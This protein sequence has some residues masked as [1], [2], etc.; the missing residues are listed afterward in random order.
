[1]ALCLGPSFLFDHCPPGCTQVVPAEGKGGLGEETAPIASAKG[2]L[3]SEGEFASSISKMTSASFPQKTYLPSCFLL[4]P[5]LD[6]PGAAAHPGDKLESSL[7]SKRRLG[8]ARTMCPP[9]ATHQPRPP[10]VPLL[11]QC[12]VCAG[13]FIVVILPKCAW[14]V[15][16]RSRL[17]WSCSW[18]QV[19]CSG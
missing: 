10:S 18:G 11:P 2:G 13:G 1:M 9:A 15:K 4:Q 6:A 17:T 19:S 7:G 12:G 8:A 14:K 3:G 5:C 16:F